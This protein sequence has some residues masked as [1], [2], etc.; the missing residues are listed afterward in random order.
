MEAL[1]RYLSATGLDKAS[2]ESNFDDNTY[3]YKS[4]L[5]LIY[6]SEV[7]PQ[8]DDFFKIYNNIWCENKSEIFLLLDQD[9][10]YLCDSKTK[11]T[12]HNLLNQI[13]IKSFVYAKNSPESLEIVDM[14]HKNNID[15]GVLWEEIYYFLQKRIRE[16]KRKTIDEDLLDNLIKTKENI[17][18]LLGNKSRSYIHAQK[19]IDRC[20]FIRFIEDKIDSDKLKDIL[21]KKDEKKL[22]DL[23]KFYND[24]LNGDLFKEDYSSLKFSKNILNELNKIFGNIYA[25][26]SGQQTL[27]PYEFSRIPISLISQ[28]YEK[29]LRP[30][31]RTKTGA[32][33]T[34]ENV[35][36]Y[37]VTNLL[38]NPKIKRKVMNRDI[39]ILDPSCGSGIFLVKFL[40]K[41][42]ELLESKKQRKLSVKEI[43]KFIQDSIYGIDINDNALRVAAFSMYLKIFDNLTPKQIINT[44]NKKINK[45]FMFPG[46]KNKNLMNQNT[47]FNDVSFKQKFDL[48]I[49][50]P[51]WGFKFECSEKK[52]I[53][54]KWNAVSKHQSSQCFI[55]KCEDF[56]K[57][58]GLICLIVN[59]SNFE[60]QLAVNFR[61]EFVKIFSIL[62]FT[63]LQ[64]VKEI[65]FGKNSEPSVI[66][67]YSKKQKNT[68]IIFNEL[69]L[70]N[71]SLLT[72]KL[73]IKNK[74]VLAENTILK[75][76]N[77]KPFM[78][79]NFNYL[80][81]L[82][83]ISSHEKTLEN[84]SS[85]YKVGVRKYSAPKHGNKYLFYKK[86]F[87]SISKKGWFPIVDSITLVKNHQRNKPIKYVD[88]DNANL[89][90]PRTFDLFQG[91]KLIISRLWPLR[92]FQEDNTIIYDDNF[93]I[94][95]PK[96]E[97]ETYLDFFEY[98]LT[99]KLAY[100]Y[101]TI[102]YLQ[103]NSGNFS[104][105]NK[106]HI[107]SLPIP[108]ITKSVI[109]KFNSYKTKL[110][111]DKFIYNLY[112]LD[113]FHIQ[114]IE[115]FYEIHTRK[116]TYI[117]KEDILNYVDEL[118][119]GYLPYIDDKKSLNFKF[120]V[121][122]FLGAILNVSIS[123]SK[124]N[125]QFSVNNQNV[126]INLIHKNQIKNHNYLSER[127]Q[128]IYDNS[129]FFI[130]KGNNFTDWTRSEA[131]RDLR[132]ELNLIYSNLKEE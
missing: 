64:N 92:C 16:K 111:V 12:K 130:Y 15:S 103:R 38:K 26:K 48:V 68:K 50:N 127:K 58:D 40:E 85:K 2:L 6:F 67:L 31:D 3:F 110:D 84:F 113:Y 5:G 36:E 109:T 124:E 90:R 132:E 62:E 119:K 125:F 27:F 49:G 28:M 39:R 100:F 46:L 82:E 120:F 23:F 101:F 74:Y 9:K 8:S 129:D 56:I 69:E 78:D 102:N 128:K 25:Y 24:S 51:P 75:D 126:K 53:D 37:I 117:S 105:V 104:K 121:S 80:D 33:Y 106:D 65:A 73:L 44:L 108:N 66:I 79:F 63:S 94:F 72:K 112:G 19:L 7:D 35:A 96:K 95:K 18:N 32:V 1:K 17:M 11:P 61:N 70:S 88:Y 71:F 89:H 118:R 52:I 114:K 13:K 10:I 123:D 91:K 86:Y 122:K 107:S 29:L 47:L 115:D 43:T 55:F 42:V 98:L 131:I 83:Y 21:D 97:Y 57:I 87:S 81:T 20:L 59:K 76:L 99:S 34:P 22:I 93:I 30:E 41:S 4:S 77:W 54:Q 14:F 45:D 60:N 116:Y